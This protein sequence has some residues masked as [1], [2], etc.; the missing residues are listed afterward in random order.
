[1]T[2]RNLKARHL[3]RALYPAPGGLCFATGAKVSL[4]CPF[5]P[6]RTGWSGSWSAT[7]RCVSSRA[8]ALSRLRC[9]AAGEAGGRVAS[10]EQ[11]I[12]G[13]PCQRAVTH[14]MAEKLCAV[15]SLRSGW[16]GAV[17]LGGR[18]SGGRGGACSLHGALYI[19]RPCGRWVGPTLRKAQQRRLGSVD[20]H[21]AWKGSET[22]KARPLLTTP[23]ASA[24]RCYGQ[25]A[26]LITC[27]LS[28]SWPA[29]AGAARWRASFLAPAVRA[30]AGAACHAWCCGSSW[31]CRTLCQRA[32]TAACGAARAR[33][34]GGI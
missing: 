18:R 25:R 29:S 33:S 22:R 11:A 17:V 19:G 3:G 4:T 8:R 34:G 9:L 5:F 23:L 15:F 2:S 31:P 32:A 1:M 30:G 12:W 20:F 27:L 10:L 6:H 26:L 24:L 21:C 13:V 7:W 16:L 28:R 14:R